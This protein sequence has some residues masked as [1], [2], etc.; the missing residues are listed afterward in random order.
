MEQDLRVRPL[1][2]AEL[3]HEEA[4]W[5]WELEID[6]GAIQ[7]TLQLK[8]G[9]SYERNKLSH[10]FPDYLGRLQPSTT[11]IRK[12][13]GTLG[14]EESSSPRQVLHCYASNSFNRQCVQDVLVFFRFY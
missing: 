1:C 4:T 8:R 10:L 14:V 9:P 12:T 2:D 7:T 13:P 6:Q 5:D 11:T 3:E